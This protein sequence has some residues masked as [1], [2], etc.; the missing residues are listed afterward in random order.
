MPE[1]ERVL[2]QVFLQVPE[3]RGVPF[4]ADAAHGSRLPAGEIK[5]PAAFPLV[6]VISGRRARNL[7]IPGIDAHAG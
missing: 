2:H 3:C 6:P 5:I 1:H 7:G 4:E